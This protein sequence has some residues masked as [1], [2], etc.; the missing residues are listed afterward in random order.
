MVR[1]LQRAKPLPGGHAMVVELM[2]GEVALG[3]CGDQLKTL[4][5]SCVSV[6]LTDPRRTVGA[7]CHI[8]HVG[9][10]NAANAKNT[11]YGEVAINAMFARLR[12]VGVDPRQC[13]AYVFGGGNMFPQQYGVR[14]VGVANV[15]WV[16]DTLH[17]Q[18]IHVIDHCLGGTGYRKLLWTVGPDEPQVQTV[19]T[20][21][22]TRP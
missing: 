4:L 17:A 21:T 9:T 18:G 22:G 2:P 16:L 6:I 8:V 5:G 19:S 20:E 11:A 13:D 15:D 12:A 3:Q 1:K 14:H 10:P 7:M